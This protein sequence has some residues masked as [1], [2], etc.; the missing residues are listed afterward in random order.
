MYVIK[1]SKHNP[2]LVPDRDNYWESFATFNLCPIKH[3]RGYHTLYRAI[4]AADE[5]RSNLEQI[6]ENQ[7]AMRAHITT[8]VSALKVL[9][10]RLEQ[11]ANDK[12][13]SRLSITVC[14]L[15]LD[16]IIAGLEPA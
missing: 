16:I 9:R 15:S 1:R 10:D 4:S 14:V 2:I 11:I 5:L 6:K 13:P 8:Q 7:E 3:G 12:E